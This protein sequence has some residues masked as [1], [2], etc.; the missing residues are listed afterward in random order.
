M[1]RKIIVAGGGHGGIATA[2]ILA[3]NGYD[4]T[5][6]EKNKRDCMGYDWTDVFDKK[7]FLAAG[8]PMPSKEKYRFKNDMTLINPSRTKTLRQHV[9]EEQLEIQMERKEIYNH[10]INHAE[11]YGVKFVYETEVLSPVILGGRVVGI[12]TADETIYA[13]LVIDAAGINSPIRQKLPDALGIQNEP[14]KYDT[15]YVYRAFY[16]KTAMTNEDKYR[17]Y[18]YF[19][20]KPQ[21]CWVADDEIYTDVLIGKFEPLTE[22]DINTALEKLRE[23]NNDLGS[24][25]LRGGQ[26]A[27]IPVRH[28]L[29]LLVADGYAAIG[30][31]AFMT[32]PIIGSGIATSLKAAGMLADAIMADKNELFCADTLWKYQR[33]FYQKL[34]NG[35]APLSVIRLMISKYSPQ[36]IDRFFEKDVLNSEDITIGADST[37]ILSFIQKLLDLTSLK[38]KFKGILPDRELSVKVLAMNTKIAAVMAYTKAMPLKY[39]RK[40]V[41]TWVKGYNKLFEL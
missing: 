6:Y 1:G 11:R 25:L 30:D 10:I 20:G 36:D 16:N 22:D 12:Q 4:V 33:D 29:G 15:F 37:S 26:F 5:V 40:A 39:D 2:A 27:K 21:I 8:I 9:P 7:G 17:V 41:N 34:G 38:A 31:S 28:P 3:Q 19:E 35:L 14:G 32:V 13:D 23:I 24:E 18:L